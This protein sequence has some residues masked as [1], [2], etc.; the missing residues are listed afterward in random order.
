MI[1]FLSKTWFPLPFAKH[2]PTHF[3][4][5]AFMKNTRSLILLRFIIFFLP[6]FFILPQTQAQENKIVEL[7]AKGD[8]DATLALVRK[9]I[10]KHPDNAVA[11]YYSALIESD[12]SSPAFSTDSAYRHLWLAKKYFNMEQNKEKMKK[13]GLTFASFRSYNDT[14]CQRAL[15]LALD[16]NTVSSLAHFLQF[17]QKANP[18][19]RRQATLA[20]E[21]ATFRKAEKSGKE[22][23]YRDFIRAYPSGKYTPVAWEYV[24]SS[25]YDHI[26]NSTNPDTLKNYLKKFPRSPH[27][28][29]VIRRIDS[30]QFSSSVQPDDWESYRDF[31][32][33]FPQN[34][35][36]AIAEDTLYNVFLRSSDYDLRHELMEY[37]ATYF[38]GPRRV[39]MLRLYH[40]YLC[41]DGDAVTI[42]NFYEQYDDP[43]FDDIRDEE[44]RWAKAADSLSL[45]RS[46]DPGM[47][48]RYDDY[49]S[50]ALDKDLAFVA[51][52]R[53]IS[54][55]LARSDKKAALITLRHYRSLYSDSTMR[56]AQLLD[57][58]I[59]LL[60]APEEKNIKPQFL[61]DV[62]NTEAEEYSPVPT[63]DEN[64][65]YFCGR[66]RSDCLD[67]GK[68]GTEDVFS[69][70]KG[71]NGRFTTAK[72]EKSIS[73]INHNE[74]PLAI[75]SDGNRLLLFRDGVI[76]EVRKLANGNWS[77]FS[78][79][80]AEV[81]L[82][83]WQSDAC[84]SPDGKA[85][86]FAAE[87]EENYNTNTHR[88][89]H[90]EHMHASDIYV[91]Y[92]D[93]DDNII[94][95]IN[96]GHVINTR[97]SDRSPQLSSDGMTL[98]FSSNGHGGL[99]HRDIFV[100]KRLS[101]D[102]WTEW[103]EPVNLGSQINTEGDEGEFRINHNATRIYY[104]RVGERRNIDIFYKPI[105]KF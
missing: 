80:P 63:S 59:S 2:F 18:D 105:P 88:F 68:H 28:D 84:L 47:T 29:K 86:L 60:S 19:F 96:L 91:V 75:S 77:T 92:R 22:Q 71:K 15:S 57:N 101:P 20:L 17:Y 55:H 7:F 30:L 97:Y 79:L 6:F 65:L 38:S 61:G 72:L 99:G 5:F 104:H 45:Y 53:V 103:S 95:P 54:P 48:K 42:V 44:I 98:F 100:S 82:N 4:I 58:L 39:D 16:S 51:I 83:D 27:R 8:T 70:T 62:I 52:Q 13:W 1:S 36:Y 66:F 21:E 34:S 87:C 49:I 76:G 24:Y 41:S 81:N 50:H 85:I 25:N 31:L 78:E 33:S 69:S 32:N 10:S 74:A 90:G 40:D 43:I 12:A 3:I 9:T 102:S 64:T 56:N 14:I 11:L 26:A 93:S 94:G 23:D 46:F 35:F 37:G 73:T 89:Y 67:E